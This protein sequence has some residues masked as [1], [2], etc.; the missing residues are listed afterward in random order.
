M[1]NISMVS[2][3]LLNKPSLAVMATKKAGILEGLKLIP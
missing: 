1:V 2:F 3:I